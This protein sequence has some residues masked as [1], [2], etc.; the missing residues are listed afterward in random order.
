MPDDELQPAR[1]LL[2]QR[3][4]ARR[5]FRSAGVATS[6]NSFAACTSSASRTT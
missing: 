2:R 1:F 6:A 3:I 5:S 4:D